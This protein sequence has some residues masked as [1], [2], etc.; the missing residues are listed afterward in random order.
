VVPTNS[1][2]YQVNR[3]SFLSSCL[4]GAVLGLARHLPMPAPAKVVEQPS[5]VVR[6]EFDM[7]Y[8]QKIIDP[9]LIFRINGVEV[10]ARGHDAVRRIL[11]P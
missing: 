6:Y 5:K 7:V 2:W 8:G 3:R 11:Q 4:A 9:R 1:R 10:P